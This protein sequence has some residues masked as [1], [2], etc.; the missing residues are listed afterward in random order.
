MAK[1]YLA[2]SQNEQAQTPFEFPTGIK[3]YSLEEALYHQFIHWRRVSQDFLCDSFIRWVEVDLGLL[4][5]GAKL[6]KISRTPNFSMLF[7][8][9]LTVVDYLP[10]EG[11]SS[12]QRELATWERRKTWEKLAEQGDYFAGLGQYERAYNLYSKALRYQENEKLL[13]NCGV[14]LLNM[15]RYNE[16][17]S[18]FAQALAYK[19]E[20]LQLSFNLIEANIFAGNFN[21]ASHLIKQASA[22]SPGN[23]EI[24]YFQAEIYF[25]EKNYF[26]AIKLYEKSAEMKYDPE[27]IYRLCDCYMRIRQYDKA[28]STMQMIK[29]QDKAFL[30]RQAK[31]YAGTGNV[32]MAIRSI[33]KALLNHVGDGELWIILAGYHRMD[34]DLTKASGAITKAL[35]LLPE[36]PTALLEAARIRKAQGRIKEYQSG[37]NKILT[38]LKKNYREIISER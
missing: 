27:Y 8:A 14:A 35:S 6:R 1:L 26:E 33:E 7:L 30:V 20:N 16:A 24:Y 21:E 23:P 19:P 12:L 34:Y 11:L 32:P 2:A 28:L 38:K 3:V 10:K 31:Y 37:L 5:I 15:G 36:N 4:S 17:A 25:H 13:N 18:S 22:K 9:F 29:E